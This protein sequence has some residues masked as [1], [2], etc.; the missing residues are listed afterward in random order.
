MFKQGIKARGGS[1]ALRAFTRAIGCF[2]ELVRKF[3]LE[4]KTGY[5]RVLFAQYVKKDIESNGYVRKMR[6]SGTLLKN[7][8]D[9]ALYMSSFGLNQNCMDPHFEESLKGLQSLVI[10][11]RELERYQELFRLIDLYNELHQFYP[12]K[13]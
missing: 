12:D 8:R 9:A 6:E 11:I 4:G 13:N 5:V 10:F 2:N 7:L 3:M 1:L